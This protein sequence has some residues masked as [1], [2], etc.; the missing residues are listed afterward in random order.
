MRTSTIVIAVGVIAFVLPVPGT[1]I[2]GGILV[3]AGVAEY[4]GIAALNISGI[5]GLVPYL[6][7]LFILLVRPR[8]LFGEEGLLE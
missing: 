7:M 5:R 8:G 4:T 2:L 3:L 6:V 1:F